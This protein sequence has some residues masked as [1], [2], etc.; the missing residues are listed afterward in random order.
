M[1][2]SCESSRV[3]AH[4]HDFTHSAFRD[5]AASTLRAETRS[6]SSRSATAYTHNEQLHNEL[7][8]PPEERDRSVVDQGPEAYSETKEQELR[9]AC[10][11]F[12][13]EDVRILGA[14]EPFRVARSPEIVDSSGTSSSSCVPTS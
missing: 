10:S 3:A 14:E 11:F 1:N 9:E 5:C 4:P 6:P 13:I 8:K 7:M 12:G 2:T